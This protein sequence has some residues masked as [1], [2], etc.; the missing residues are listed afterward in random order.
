[1]KTLPI[2]IS[3]FSKIRQDN[4]YYVDKTQFIHKLVNNGTYYFLSRPRRFGKSLFIDT[5]KQA[6][7]AE[8][9]YFKGLFLEN[10]WNWDIKYPV[11]HISFGKGVIQSSEQLNELI[12]YCLDQHYEDY[13]IENKYTLVNIRFSSY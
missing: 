2:G 6:F 1:M 7:L 3:S 9:Q 13:Q 10:N 8:K 12:H 4:Y 5:L 11:I